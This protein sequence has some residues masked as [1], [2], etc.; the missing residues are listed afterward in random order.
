[1]TLNS[2]QSLPE[3]RDRLLEAASRVFAEQGFR[4]ATVREICELA[5]ANI[6]AVNYHF[7]DKERL[8]RA[9][10]AHAAAAALERHPIG[11]GLPDDP[12]PEERLCAFVLGFVERLLDEG[13][14]SWHTHLMARE[15]IEPTG[16]LR[17]VADTYARPQFELLRAV[18]TD[19]LGPAATP[20]RVRLCCCTVVGQCLFYRNCRP[21]VE[22]LMPEERYGP[23]LRERIVAHVCDVCVRAFESMRSDAEA[24][25]RAGRR[26]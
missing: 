13:R 2:S 12:T 24:Q 8:Y 7:G 18:V 10:V 9:V 15:M 20:E 26:P 21:M 4:A 19:L 25:A 6:A 1:M 17:E 5:R 22:L 23:R 3:T 16:V 11:A 14:P